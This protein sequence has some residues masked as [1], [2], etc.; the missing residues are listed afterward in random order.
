MA[1]KL[2]KQERKAMIEEVEKK[3]AEHPVK[4]TE[5]GFATID[6]EAEK[7]EDEK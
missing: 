7:L 2:S 6:K 3:R 4:K 1:G 5:S